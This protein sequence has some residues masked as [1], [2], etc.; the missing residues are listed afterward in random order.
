MCGIVGYTGKRQALKVLIP[1]LR[2][3]EYRGYD[4]A[5]VTV[6]TARGL[7]IE[8]CPGRID[9]LKRR[10]DRRM[11]GARSGIGLGHTRW[12]THG[13]PNQVNAHPHISCGGRVALVHNGIIEN[14][15]EI[16]R[17]LVGHRFRSETDTEVVAHLFEEQLR[18]HK[19][20]EAL[21]RTVRRLQGSF[22]LAAILKDA[23]GE[24][25][26]ARQGS[27][28]V[29]GRADG[30]T[31]LASDTPAI[32]PVTRR[33]IYLNDGEIAQLSPDAVRIWT[34]GMK[35]RRPRVTTIEWTR[36][37]AERG[38]FAHYMLKEIH[39]Q[40]E[41]AV[42]ELAG[43]LSPTL[44][45][46]T[47]PLKRVNRIVIGACGTAWHA[48]LY[49]KYA[50]EE[51]AGLPVDVMA[52]SELR[53]SAVPFDRRTLM[54]AIT[55]SGETAD[56]LAAAR[57]AQRRGARVLALTNTRFSSITREAD[58]VLY[59]RA[60]WEVG[61]AATKT[62]VS[63][64]INAALLAIHLGTVRRNLKSR[65]LLREL[66][67]LPELLRE[68]LDLTEEIRR[69]ARL[70]ARK[71]D[72][73][74]IGRRY[75]L[76]TAF[77]GA[78]KMKEITYLHAEGYGGGEM[79]HGPLALVDKQMTT[80]A[81]AVEGSVRKK[82]ISNIREIKARGGKIVAVA[83]RGDREIAGL[84]DHV[85]SIGQIEEIFSPVLAVVP[86]QLLAYYTAVRLGR[87]VDRPRNLAKSVTVE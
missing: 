8:K 21:A 80:C 74:Y 64:L 28:L 46:L 10:L 76:P 13:A 39:E 22:A 68:T 20:I 70:Y 31:I 86:L 63:Q 56:T 48:G 62:Y 4:S 45:D 79:K 27:P 83:T 6:A 26:A 85:L 17:S 11:N 53:A 30:E 57:T 36:Q 37:E 43:R 42:R 14:F 34:F 67:R 84:A 15:A 5:G 3:L 66:E 59:T 58:A 2:T 9:V 61:V 54:I 7:R 81:L 29:I 71:H 73:L 35:E 25:Y 32:L 12:A 40:P 23:P 47:L 51:L 87:D 78:L 44:A 72:F 82:M 38:G 75:N 77:E 1:A 33:V 24:I 19:P 18:K 65:R 49:A 52:A 16:R 60:G 55:Q 69:I 41:V 50:I